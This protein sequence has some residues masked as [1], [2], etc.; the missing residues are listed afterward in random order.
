MATSGEKGWGGGK[1]H[2]IYTQNL[3]NF[4]TTGYAE[5]SALLR[6]VIFE[7][8][9]YSTILMSPLCAQIMGLF[10]KTGHERGTT[11]LKSLTT[12]TIL[13]CSAKNCKRT[14]SEIRKLWAF[15]DNDCTF[16]ARV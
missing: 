7:K 11:T 15:K 3:S 8:E 4:D 9:S 13:L 2:K 16:G 14:G 12:G 5:H 1:R 10:C 6:I